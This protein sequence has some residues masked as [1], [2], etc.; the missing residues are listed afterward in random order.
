MAL[1]RSFSI[2]NKCSVRYWKYLKKEKEKER[3][4]KRRRSGRGERKGREKGEGGKEKEEEKKVATT[5]NE[6]NLYMLH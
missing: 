4:R 1:C 6:L 3:R 5:K 2:A